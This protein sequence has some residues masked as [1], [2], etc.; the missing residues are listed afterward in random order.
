M[1][2]TIIFLILFLLFGLLFIFLLFK[3]CNNSKENLCLC[4]GMNKK[5]CPNQ[6]LLLNLYNNNNLTEYSNLIKKKSMPSYLYN[7]N[8]IYYNSF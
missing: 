8:Y 1:N 3:D 4:H 2:I 7:D 5:I 6:S